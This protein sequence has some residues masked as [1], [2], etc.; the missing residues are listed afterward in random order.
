MKTKLSKR[1]PFSKTNTTWLLFL[2]IT[3]TIPMTVMAQI[4]A[5]LIHEDQVTPDK[6]N[7]YVSVAKDFKALCEKHNFSESW[8][9]AQMDNGYF[10][11]ISSIENFADLD[12][13]VMADL[14]EKVGEEAFQKYFDRFNQCYDKHGSYISLLNEELSYMPNG[15]NLEQNDENY[16]RWFFMESSAQ[17]VSKVKEKIKA[18]KA[19]FT[20]K[21]SKMYYRIY[22]NGFGLI[23]DR[24]VVVIS[25][26]SAL[27]YEQKS[28]AN[29]K[30]LGEES[31]ALFDD[32]YNLLSAYNEISGRMRPD[33]G[34]IKK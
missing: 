27:D 13:N 32:L 15:M 24:F 25:A 17:N 4:Q 26:K 30:L 14:A 8:S 16:R 1:L 9:V 29:R 21:N 31:R 18:I 6:H 28:E 34:Y 10:L 2:L 12:K 5:F 11:T 19:L 22:Q 20:D 3:F 33:L 7:A 23:G